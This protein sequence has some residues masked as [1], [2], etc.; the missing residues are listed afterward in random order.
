MKKATILKPG[1]HVGIIAPGAAFNHE[2][3]ES[4]IAVIKSLG[5][6]TV[7]AKNLNKKDFIF[8]GTVKNRV[9]DFLAMARDPNIKAVWC[10]RGGY[11]TYSVA[12]ELALNHSKPPKCGPKLV[13]GLSDITALHLFLTQKWKWPVLHAPLVDRLGHA[14]HKGLEP[15]VL[16]KTLFDSKFRLIVQS[17]LTHLGARK[18]V[19]GLLTGGNLALLSASIGSAW[20]VDTRGKILFIEDIGEPA[21]RI[22][23]MLTQLESAGKF[24]GVRGVVVGDFTECVDSDGRERWLT[25]FKRHF[26]R[27]KFPVILG[28]H[29][30]HGK[31]RL[32]LPMGVNVKLCTLK[33]SALSFEVIESVCHP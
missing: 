26:G 6:K 8:S 2:K 9:D 19:T 1:E 4:G 25:V 10:V 7:F 23:R 5:L 14:L 18:N 30:G 20:E 29:S 15:Q 32:T 22:D 11:G 28:V 33:N 16:S 17:R 21:Y 3:F 12:Q 24:S 31:V 13:I 27:A